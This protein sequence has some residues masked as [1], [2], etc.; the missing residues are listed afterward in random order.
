MKQNHFLNFLI[1]GGYAFIPWILIL[2]VLSLTFHFPHAVFVLLHYVLNVLLFFIAFRF[3]YRTYPHAN[4]FFT[5][6]KV[7]L[8]LCLFEIILWIFFGQPQKPFL[9]YI[10]FLFPAF[11]IVTTIYA[12]GK[13]QN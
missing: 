9:N 6:L 10:D 7:L 1:V 11:L 2:F 12:V 5:T 4:P 13:Q 3:F 8:F